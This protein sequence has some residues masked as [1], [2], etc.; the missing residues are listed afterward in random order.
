[1]ALMVIAREP[2]FDVVES[3]E[4][5]YPAA[6]PMWVN[7]V[8]EMNEAALRPWPGEAHSVGL[9]S[10]MAELEIGSF[11]VLVLL[12]GFEG[13]T[14]SR[15]FLQGCRHELTRQRSRKSRPMSCV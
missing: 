9:Y 8:Y 5:G 12:L 7:W 6:H 11:Y 3:P 15:Y 10:Q 13:K 1:M 14:L 2:S 4:R